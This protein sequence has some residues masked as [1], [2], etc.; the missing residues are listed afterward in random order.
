[1]RILLFLIIF[2][3]LVVQVNAWNS[4]N[5]RAL[6]DK[7]YYSLDFNTQ[8]KLNL[9]YI[10]KG[11]TDPDL[12]FHDTRLHHYPPSYNK[13]LGWLEKAKTSYINQDYN[14]ASY[15]FGVA[16]HYISD[17]F[18]APH[19]ISKE[20]STLHSEF[21]NVKNY[22]FKT[23]CHNNKLELNHSLYLG[24]L[25]KDDWMLWVLNKNQSIPEKELEQVLYLL[26]PTALEI[27]NSSCNNF[28]TE[29]VKN[30][31]NFINKN[32]IIF[33]GIL[34]IIY[35]IYYLNKKYKFIKRIRF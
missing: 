17:S 34:I 21:E 10:E 23:K 2:F 4:I 24:S 29:I 19:Y 14:D 6:V 35:L 16:S 25:N 26:Y 7:V 20:P 22:K 5:H 30:K 11:S 12:V 15:S 3:I 33:L 32:L 27:F 28:E 9:S 1:M 13:T 8:S 31:F 18:V